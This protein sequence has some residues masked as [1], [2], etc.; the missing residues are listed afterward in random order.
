MKRRSIWSTLVVALLACGTAGCGVDK[1]PEVHGKVT[2]DG[3][4]VADADVSFRAADNDP[5]KPGAVAKTGD[6]GT[7]SILPDEDSGASLPPG[8]YVVVIS[9][10]VDKTGGKLPPEMKED[11]EQMVAAGMARESLPARYSNEQKTELK[12]EIK[13]EKNDLTFDLKSK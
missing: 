8:N 13:P 1:G 4:P 12:A 3:Q 5:T 11:L 10:M 2:M 7:F 6:D 9:K